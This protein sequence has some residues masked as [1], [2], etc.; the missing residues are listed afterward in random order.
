MTQVS[1]RIPAQPNAGF[2]QLWRISEPALFGLGLRDDFQPDSDLDILV[3]FAPDAGWGPL[4][5]IR[6][7]QELAAILDREVDLLTQRSVEQNHNGIRRQQIL[8]AAEVVYES[9]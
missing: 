6:M 1:T 3:A 4:D 9:R 5:Y 8:D 7:E 2:C